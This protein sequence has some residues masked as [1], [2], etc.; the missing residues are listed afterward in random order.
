MKQGWLI[1][2]RRGVG[3]LYRL[4]DGLIISVGLIF[5][6]QY[7]QYEISSEWLLL[8]S[9]STIGF[10]LMAESLEVYRSWRADSFLKMV[11][12]TIASWCV[13]LGV[14]LS[15]IYVTKTS[16]LFSRLVIGCWA[17]STGVLF[18]AWRFSHRLLLMFLRTRGYNSRKAVIIGLNESGLRLAGNIEAE[19]HLGIKLSGFYRSE[20]DQVDEKMLDGF[21]PRYS[22]LGDVAQALADARDGKVDL[23]YIA[24]PLRAEKHIAQLLIEFADTPATVHVVTD[25]FVSNLI[26]GRLYHVGDSNILSVYDTPIEGITGWIKRVEDLVLSA[27]ILT[28]ISPLMLVIG[29]AIKV[30]SPGPAIFKQTRYGLDGRPIDV[31]KFRTMST[32]DNGEIVVQACKNDRRVTPIG[33]FLRKTSL[34]ELPQFINVLQGSMSVVGPRP[35]AVAHNEQY[36]KCVSGYML[37]H[38]VKPGITGWAQINGWRGETDTIE[39]MEKRVEYDLQYIRHWSLLLDV[40]ILFAT[41][42]IG[43]I[44]K[45][46]Y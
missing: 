36:R 10:A 12:Y 22:V 34:D 13:L 44:N 39:K 15:V 23:C 14:A 16:D 25:L 45:N 18:I 2:H 28:V 20:Y 46:A 6:V 42:M 17:V 31:W 24:L 19:V 3:V 30:T 41:I 7:F 8:A 5:W 1:R 29:L 37:R 38:K 33:R 4:F 43:F 27:V 21:G 9:V 35:H 40:K 32:Q 26:H 11:S